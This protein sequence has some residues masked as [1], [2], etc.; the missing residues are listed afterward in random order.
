MPLLTQ[1]GSTD[2]HRRETQRHA[3]LGR[4]LI[5]TGG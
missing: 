3:Q 2:V 5:G 4:R 1:H